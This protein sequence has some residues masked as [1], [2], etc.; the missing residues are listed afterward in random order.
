[1]ACEFLGIGDLHL[2]DHLGTGGLAKY[3]EDHDRMVESEVMRVLAYGEKKGVKH[4][5]FYGDIFENPRGS[6]PGM[7]ALSRILTTPGFEFHVILGNHDM[8]GRTPE[9]GHA[10]EVVQEF[11]SAMKPNV[12]FYFK[13]ADVV[14]DGAPFRFLPFPKRKFHSKALNVCHIDVYGA[15]SDNGRE[16]LNEDRDKSNNLVVAGHIHTNQRIRNTYYSG[17]LYQTCF[18]EGQ[19]KFFHH[20]TFKNVDD[21]EITSIPFKPKYKLHT[22]TVEDKSDLPRDLDSTDLVK[23]VLKDGSMITSDD[24]RHLNV[25]VVRSFQSKAQLASVLT[26]D[27]PTNGIDTKI[28]TKEFFDVWVG[29]LDVE[30]DLKSRIVSTRKRI[31]SSI[32]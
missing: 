12:H 20:G 30:D 26:E 28:S 2:T 24:Y 5:I 22:I 13:G 23:L 25:V 18:G 16:I 14:L 9:V 4:I 27:M 29:G 21:Y 10:L 7:Q 17:T 1:M 15:I 3:I 32:R 8:I 31:L 19:S 6:Y 11:K